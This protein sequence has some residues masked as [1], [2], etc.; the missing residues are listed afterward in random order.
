M[1]RANGAGGATSMPVARYFLFV[2]GVLLALLF[3]LDAFA[4]QQAAVASNCRARPRSTRPSCAFVPTRN[5]RNGWYTT[6][7]CPP[8]FPRPRR[9][10]LP[11]FRL[12]R[13]PISLRRRG[14]VTLLP[15]SFRP[16]RSSKSSLNRRL[17]AQA[18]DCEG[19]P[20][21]ADALCPAAAHFGFFGTAPGTAPGK[22][23][24]RALRPWA[25]RLS[26]AASGSCRQ[27]RCSRSAARPLPSGNGSH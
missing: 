7:A 12:H 9:P 18:Q 20:V 21:P 14:C 25:C 10:R 2:G 22:P 4:P 26:A 17:N 5:C 23:R 11:L 16:R 6:P 3:A 13:S 19:K 24:N 15:S 1:N 8:L 27:N